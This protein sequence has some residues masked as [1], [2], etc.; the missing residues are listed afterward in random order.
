M[1]HE[2][3]EFWVRVLTTLDEFRE[4]GLLSLILLSLTFFTCKI[5][6]PILMGLLLIE[7]CHHK[8]LTEVAHMAG[9]PTCWTELPSLQLPGYIQPPTPLSQLPDQPMGA[10]SLSLQSHSFHSLNLGST[11]RNLYQPLAP[12]TA[13]LKNT[14]AV[15]HPCSVSNV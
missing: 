5:N 6:T 2:M 12:E 3:S 8:W 4:S 13:P 11:F 10:E 7:K 1:N 14:Q 15:T 9:P